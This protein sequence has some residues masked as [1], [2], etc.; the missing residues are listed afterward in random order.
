MKTK[1]IIIQTLLLFSLSVLAKGN[2]Q[3]TATNTKNKSY[4]G[5][6]LGYLSE[7]AYFAHITSWRSI[8]PWFDV[9][10]GLGVR[11]NSYWKKSVIPVFL[12]LKAGMPDKK[13]SP[14]VS[15]KAGY[16]L[17]GGVLF[18]PKF[19][20]SIKNTDNKAINLGLGYEMLQTGNSYYSKRVEN[21]VLLSVGITW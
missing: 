15:A 8:K 20:L 6:E 19:G 9:G 18:S 4:G 16:A 3:Q 1:N 13:Y 17:G 11:Y 5:L 14:F 2:N 10:M 21:S 7:Q 12:D